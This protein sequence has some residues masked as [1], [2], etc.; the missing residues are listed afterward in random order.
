MS[1]IKND[2]IYETSKLETQFVKESAEFMYQSTDVK[3]EYTYDE[4]Q[5]WF[6]QTQKWEMVNG[7]PYAMASAS[8][9]HQEIS[10]KLAH[11]IETYLS[12]KECRLFTTLEV[13]LDFKKGKDTFLIPDL[14]VLC[15]KSKL[16]K[17]G[18]EG[19]PDIVIEILSPSTG[20]HDRLLK[21]NWYAQA[22]VKEYWI[23]DPEHEIIEVSTLG[24]D[25]I[26]S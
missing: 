22:G 5:S 24:D 14:L 20:R 19:A 25:G 21:R 26:Y 18:V 13:R 10:G 4:V 11:K 9:R 8:P 7:I 15:D 23:V 1:D 12:G 6:T 16:G 17:R 3:K 2:I